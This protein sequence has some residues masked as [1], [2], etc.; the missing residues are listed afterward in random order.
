MAGRFDRILELSVGKEVLDCGS[1]GGDDSDAAMSRIAYV[2]IAKRA[3]SCLGIDIQPQ[4]VA[5]ARAHGANIIEGDVERM[6]L[7]REFDLIVA[8]DLIEHL[9]RPGDFLDRARTHL[10]DDGRLVIATPN[11]FSLNNLL[12]YTL[13]LEPGVNPEHTCWY[14][15]VTLRQLLERHGFR[16][17]EEYWQDYRTRAPVA[18]A[19]RLRPNLASAII[20]VAGKVVHR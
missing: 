4:A 3:R 18:L 20:V 14:D 12:K 5:R 17:E 9:A 16:P 13:G 2:E 15:F 8:A 6:E 1:I 7:G 10:R 19:L 11:A